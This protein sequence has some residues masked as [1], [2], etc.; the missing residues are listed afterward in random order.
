MNGIVARGEATALRQ[1]AL[2]G[3][4]L[5]ALGLPSGPAVGVALER[6]LDLVLEDPSRNTRDQLQE[7]VRQ[8]Q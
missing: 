3:S 8:W 2:T 1:L 4:D 5:L 7:A 6:L